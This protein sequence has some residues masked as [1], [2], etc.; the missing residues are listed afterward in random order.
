M[1]HRDFWLI[2]PIPSSV[3]GRERFHATT[4]RILGIEK[5][6]AMLDLNVQGG[7][8][9]RGLFLWARRFCGWGF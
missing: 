8:V 3:R 7:V 9:N 1:K 5:I 2:S 4:H 6:I